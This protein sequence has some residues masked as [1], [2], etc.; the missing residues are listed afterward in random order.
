MCKG[1]FNFRTNL[2][3]LGFLAGEMAQPVK[4]A[5]LKPDYLS[6]IPGTHMVERQNS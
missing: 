3:C 5:A 4:G 6:S 1:L 2:K